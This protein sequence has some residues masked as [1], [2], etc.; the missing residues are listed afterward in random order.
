MRMPARARDE[1]DVRHVVVDGRALSGT[2]SAEA[3]EASNCTRKKEWPWRFDGTVFDE[4]ESLRQ[5]RRPPEA[6]GNPSNADDDQCARG[7]FREIDLRWS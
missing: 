3:E 2:R 4:F 7:G 6:C 5:P 1:R